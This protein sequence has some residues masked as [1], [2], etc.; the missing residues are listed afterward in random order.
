MPRAFERVTSVGS[1]NSEQSARRV[2]GGCVEKRWMNFI[3]RSDDPRRSRAVTL[4]IASS[5]SC[6]WDGSANSVRARHRVSL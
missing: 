1:G 6:S 3:A 5:L 4:R 2:A